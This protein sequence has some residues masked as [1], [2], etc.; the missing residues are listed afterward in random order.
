M[1]IVNHSSNVKI[2]PCFKNLCNNLL[3]EYINSPRFYF[4]AGQC[5]TDILLSYPNTDVL[6]PEEFIHVN[7][8][9]YEYLDFNQS[10]EIKC[11][12]GYFSI[13]VHDKRMVDSRCLANETWS[14]L[15]HCVGTY[16]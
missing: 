11:L 6:V 5:Y 10:V 15:P 7:A 16:L 8:S 1:D 14:L 2:V 3:K 9:G 4:T 12:P 13:D